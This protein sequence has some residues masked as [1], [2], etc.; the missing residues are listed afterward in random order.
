LNL[1]NERGYTMSK[2]SDDEG[3]YTVG[4]IIAYNTHLNL[5][6]EGGYTVSKQ[7]DDEGGYTVGNIIV[8][9]THSNLR[10]EGGYTVGNMIVYNTHLNLSCGTPRDTV[11]SDARSRNKFNSWVFRV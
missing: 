5:R 10:N 3:G 2:Q 1:R 9:N 8:Y 4:N 6:N 7:S 11:Q